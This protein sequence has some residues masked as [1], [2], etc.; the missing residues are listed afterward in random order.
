MI[1]DRD[2]EF[3]GK[4]TLK[5]DDVGR[6]KE[7]NDKF[8]YNNFTITPRLSIAANQVY[9]KT[10]HILMFTHHNKSIERRWLERELPS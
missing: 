9:I 3:G 4:D 5:R 1:K 2:K 6:K 8:K 10:S 7:G